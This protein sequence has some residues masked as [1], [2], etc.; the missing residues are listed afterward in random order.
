MNSRLILIQALIMAFSSF[1]VAG[2]H[3]EDER[4]F[5]SAS[6]NIQIQ[7]LAR[8][9]A[10]MIPNN[11]WANLKNV[12]NL[13]QKRN[14]CPDERYSQIPSVARC[15][16]VLIAPQILLT[17]YHCVPTPEDCAANSW[18]FNFQKDDLD[19]ALNQKQQ[20]NRYSCKR[21]ISA[22]RNL[23]TL[24]DFSIIELDRPVIN[25]EPVKIAK[26]QKLANEA[27][28]FM[29]GHPYGLPLMTTGPSAILN[30]NLDHYFETELDAFAGNSG[31]PVFNAETMELEGIFVRGGTDEVSDLDTDDLC[32]RWYSCEIGTDSCQTEDVTRIQ[33]IL[34]SH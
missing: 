7:N 21:L 26:Q 30:N 29:L 16:G 33:S 10:A 1:A 5:V 31:S 8:A 11:I 3:G 4:Q 9:T 23:M 12:Q 32:K 25:A 17:T 34:M 20:L 18:S 19:Q 2:N 14:F 15:T 22:E 27:K 6:S 24:K 13:I 28:V